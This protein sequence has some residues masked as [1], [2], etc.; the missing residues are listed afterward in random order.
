MSKVFK[1]TWK[2]RNR[3]NRKKNQISYFSNFY[4]LS[5]G[6]LY[7]QFTMTHLA[8]MSKSGQIHRKDAKWVEANVNLIFWFL[9][10]LVFQLWSILYWIHN[11]FYIRIASPQA[12]N[13]FGLSP[14]SQLISGYHWLAFL[15]K[16]RVSTT[17][18]KILSKL[19]FVAKF[20]RMMR[21]ALKLIF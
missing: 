21:N 5:Y 20:S 18:K 12:P 17:K 16:V 15:N 3:L 8:L 19:F 6:W 13:T 11:Y 9:Q 4:F 2:I 14:P 10:S 7:I 1:F